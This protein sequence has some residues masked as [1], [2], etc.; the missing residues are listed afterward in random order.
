LD[1]KLTAATG[2][3]QAEFF[4]PPPS[5]PRS[6]IYFFVE[7]FILGGVD[8]MGFVVWRFNCIMV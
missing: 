4:S 7:K 2:I 8:S 5:P 1:F 6:R 3:S